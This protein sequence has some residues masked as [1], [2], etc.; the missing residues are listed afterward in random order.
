M[1]GV[2]AFRTIVG[3]A[4]TEDFL[5]FFVQQVVSPS[6]FCCC[7]APCSTPCHFSLK[8]QMPKMGSGMQDASVAVLDNASIHRKED[9]K[10]ITR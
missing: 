7:C 10:S 2:L 8:S 4:S 9:M 6:K 3:S 1:K 5:S